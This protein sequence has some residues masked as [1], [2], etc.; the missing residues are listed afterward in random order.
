MVLNNTSSQIVGDVATV[1]LNKDPMSVEPLR[2]RLGAKSLI[3]GKAK[4]SRF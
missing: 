1:D 2:V 3:T 4:W